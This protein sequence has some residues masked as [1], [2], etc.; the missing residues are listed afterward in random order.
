MRDRI[1]PKTAERVAALAR[2]VDAETLAEFIVC[3]YL[4]L[5]GRVE[6]A[7]QRLAQEREYERC[8]REVDAL[9]AE[10]RARHEREKGRLK[11]PEDILRALRIDDLVSKR[12]DALR[13]RQDELRAALY[14]RS[15]TE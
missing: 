3:N 6:D 4:Y 12:M 2:Q 15:R 13:K 7:V 10:Q 8:D 9:L 5:G 11:T 1:H 14:P